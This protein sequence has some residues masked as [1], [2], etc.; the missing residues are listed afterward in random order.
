MF[1]KIK[2]LIKKT[3]GLILTWTG[4]HTKSDVQIINICYFFQWYSPNI[5]ILRNE[6]F[7]GEFY[8]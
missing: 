6:E 1:Y 7:V 4:K 3:L 2:Q 8:N 5:A